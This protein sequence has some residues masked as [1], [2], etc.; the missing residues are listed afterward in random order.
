MKLLKTYATLAILN[1]ILVSAVVMG[2]PALRGHAEQGRPERVSVS[3]TETPFPT[4]TKTVV[5]IKRVVVV[6]P[7]EGQQRSSSTTIQ[8]SAQNTAAVPPAAASTPDTRCIIT[9]DGAKYDVTQFRSMHS[10]GN[11]FSC[12]SDMS[13]TFWSQHGQ[14]TLNQMAQYRI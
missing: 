6:K 11:I 7:T 5:H 12:G 14:G 2:V 3:P 13:A 9:I 1:W 4:P 10:G 8:P